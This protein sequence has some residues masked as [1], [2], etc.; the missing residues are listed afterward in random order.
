MQISVGS[1]VLCSLSTGEIYCTCWR[2]C[3]DCFFDYSTPSIN[4]QFTLSGAPRNVL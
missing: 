1:L 2:G 3:C 4:S